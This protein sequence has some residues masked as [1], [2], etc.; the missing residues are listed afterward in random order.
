MYWDQGPHYSN[1]NKHDR[2]QL[3]AEKS[4]DMDNTEQLQAHWS[5]ALCCIIIVMQF[6]KNEI[7]ASLSEG[8]NFPFETRH[9]PIMLDAV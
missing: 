9:K 4:M 5:I 8:N 7:A 1:V 2:K 3:Q 6:L